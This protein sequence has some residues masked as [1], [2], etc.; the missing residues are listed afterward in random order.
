MQFKK[1]TGS[2]D[3]ARYSRV[4]ATKKG[5]MA[6]TFKTQNSQ[7]YMEMG[8]P[9][10]PQIDADNCFEDLVTKESW[11]I[12]NRGRATPHLAMSVGRYVGRS[13]TFLNFERFLYYCFCQTIRN[14]IAVYLALVR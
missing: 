5:T 12:F 2:T 11:L 3:T 14:W 13:V 1:V 7:T 8:K 6:V 10:M 9:I 4:S